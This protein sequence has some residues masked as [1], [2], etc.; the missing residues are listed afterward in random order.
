M[1]IFSLS[2]VNSI[3]ENKNENNI[4]SNNEIQDI[5]NN[6]ETTEAIYEEN[7]IISS[8]N[9]DDLN[10]SESIV[11]SGYDIDPPETSPPQNQIWFTPNLA[12]V[13]ML[14]LF[15]QPEHWDSARSDIDVFKFYTAQVGSGG[16]GCVGNPAHD[17]GDNHLENLVD[18]QAFS[19]LGEWGIDIAIESF[20]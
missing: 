16:W 3:E 8:D 10:N 4:E 15:S 17:C 5:N 19:K 1:L 2:S 7:N 12:S 6:V 9:I 13:D 11:L 14:D 20:F 18:V